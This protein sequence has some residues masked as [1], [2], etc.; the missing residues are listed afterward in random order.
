MQSYF[1]IMVY[2]APRK[3]FTATRLLSPHRDL[4]GWQRV[5]LGTFEE[6]SYNVPLVVSAQ[7]V[8]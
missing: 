1:V 6:D 7:A 8:I 5:S 2:R 4:G 3:A